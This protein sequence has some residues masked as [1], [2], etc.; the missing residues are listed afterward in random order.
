MPVSQKMRKISRIVLV[1]ALV[2]LAVA[3]VIITIKPVWWPA[4]LALSGANIGAVLALVGEG[5]MRRVVTVIIDEKSMAPSLRIANETLPYMRLGLN[6]ETARKTAEIIQKIS[7]VEAVAITDREKVL[8]FIGPGC[9]HHPVGG[10]II[11]YAT[12]QVIASGELKIIQNKRDFNCP[13]KDC[14]CPLEAAVIAPLKCRGEIAGTVKLYKTKKGKLPASV[15][16]LAIGIAQLL[17]VQMELAELDRQAQLATKAELDALQAQINPHFLF[18][19]I[20]AISMFIRTNPEEARLLLLRLAA[21]F[22]HS[23]KRQGRYITMKEEIEYIDTYL[24]LEQARFMDKLQV[25]MDIA[26]GLLQYQIPVLTLQPLVENAVR[27]GITPKVGPGTVRIEVRQLAADLEITVS[28]DG[29]GIGPKILPRIFEP[30]FGSGNGVGLSNVNERLKILFGMG[31]GY[32]LGIESE[33]D[34]GTIVRVRLPVMLPG[35]VGKQGGG[36]GLA[37]ESFDY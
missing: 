10:Y 27:H 29:V 6:R 35:D 26:P 32:G 21:L 19:T 25:E 9:E 24:A 31:A 17:G 23:L 2:Q 15:I 8:A 34:R 5:H 33:P 22:R 20:N 11:T 3:A 18:N 16:K 12:K 30:G 36:S 37:A 1:F 13:V 28:D 4:V 7:D 14:D